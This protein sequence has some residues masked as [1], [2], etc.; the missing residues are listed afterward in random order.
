MKIT[1]ARPRL[2]P[3]PTIPGS[4]TYETA[5]RLIDRTGKVVSL[6]FPGRHNRKS[7][8][9]QLWRRVYRDYCAGHVSLEHL[10]AIK[11]AIAP[12]GLP[13]SSNEGSPTQLRYK[14]ST[15]E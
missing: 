12:K 15:D 11:R 14:G 2:V 7:A 5:V 9:D 6:H 8:F 13:G 1:V 4:G 10:Q 3:S